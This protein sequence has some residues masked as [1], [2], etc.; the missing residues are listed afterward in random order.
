MA[1]DAHLNNIIAGCKKG[2]N[3]D[4]HALVD[5][6]SDRLYGYFFRLTGSRQT[7]ADLLSDMYLKLLKKIAS[8]RGGSFENW[9]FTIAS[10][11]FHDHLRRKYR[12]AKL[13]RGL[14]EQVVEHYDPV[15]ADQMIA[16]ETK[17]KLTQAIRS[18]DPETAELV[19]LRFYGEMSFK[20]LAKMRNEP[21][22]T[23]LSKVHRAVKKLKEIMEKENE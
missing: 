5:L 17:E 23:T 19:T 10:N 18:L 2:C 15:Y 21:I 1:D 8:Y 12:Q 11:V 3:E 13:K 20:E 22:G 9:L 14:A 16:V 6:Y 4:F 7:S